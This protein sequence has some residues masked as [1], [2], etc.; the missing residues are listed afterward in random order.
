MTTS[1]LALKKKAEYDVEYRAKN[2]DKIAEYA[3]KYRAENKDKALQYKAKYQAKNKVKIRASKATR[4][5]P[6][7][8]FVRK[9]VLPPAV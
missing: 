4:S 5:G 1:E 6:R 8:W 2:K 9:A 7:L 3:A